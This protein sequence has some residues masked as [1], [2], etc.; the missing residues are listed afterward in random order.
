MNQ[1]LSEKGLPVKASGRDARMRNRLLKSTAASIV[2]ALCWGLTPAFAATGYA[3]TNATITE[4]LASPAGFY[5]YV[6]VA[7]TGGSDTCATQTVASYRFVINPTASGASVVIATALAAHAAGQ[8][9]DI[10]GTGA[11]DV[12]PDTDTIN[13]IIA[14]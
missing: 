11:C 2:I 4:V 6:S 14:H 9:I 12:W 7:P 13:F 8:T 10:Y 1:A 5:V 3:A